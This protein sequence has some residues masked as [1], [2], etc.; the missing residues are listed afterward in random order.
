MKT[1][2][3]FTVIIT[4]AEGY[5]INYVII[6][7]TLTMKQ[8]KD[9]G[10]ISLKTG[11]DVVGQETYNNVQ[12]NAPAPLYNDFLIIVNIPEEA[13]APMGQEFNCVMKYPISVST[14]RI[15]GQRVTVKLGIDAAYLAIAGGEY[16]RISMH[17]PIELEFS[18]IINPPSTTPT[19]PYSIEVRTEYY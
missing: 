16:D 13:R 5:K 3:T 12:F 6:A 1:S 8:G 19:E 10:L 4:D 7:L 14:C 11:N 2:D 17:T 9:V 18:Q 15:N